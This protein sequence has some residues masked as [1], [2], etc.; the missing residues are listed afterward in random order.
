MERRA[1]RG[2]GLRAAY[3]YSRTTDNWTLDRTG[4][5]ADQLSPFPSGSNVIRMDRG[6]LRQL[7]ILTAWCLAD[8]RFPGGIGME[9]GLRFRYRSGLAFTPGFRPGVDPNGD[10]SGRNSRPSSIT[11]PGY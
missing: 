11:F 7:D 8:Y 3:T 10:G 4:D 2:L 1:Q 5:P 9:L 6:S